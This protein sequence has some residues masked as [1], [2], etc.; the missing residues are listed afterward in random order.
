M[1]SR[2]LKGSR[3][4]HLFLLACFM[5]MCANCYAQQI[6]VPVKVQ[7][8][9]FFK[10]LSFDRTLK[11]TA[12]KEVILGVVY[13]GRNKYSRSVKEEVEDYLSENA[14]YI[15]NYPAKAVYIDLDRNDLSAVLSKYRFAA[16]YVAPLRVYDVND[17]ISLTRGGGILSI[18][19]VTEYVEKGVSVGIGLKSD[20]PMILMNLRSAKAE[21][22]DFSSQLLK[23]AKII[24]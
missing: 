15:G 4:I 5:A 22:A 20:K 1:N 16:V 3:C 24:E 7:I 23:L 14:G 17:I 18:T 6:D 9:L 13:Q 2:Y 12:D 11:Y 19:G 8:P 21:G 10:I